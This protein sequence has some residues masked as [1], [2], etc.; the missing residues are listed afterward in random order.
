MAGSGAFFDAKSFRCD[1]DIIEISFCPIWDL[2]T[3]SWRDLAP[4]SRR[5][6]TVKMYRKI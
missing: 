3:G 5:G 1:K 6:T 2:Y 4:D